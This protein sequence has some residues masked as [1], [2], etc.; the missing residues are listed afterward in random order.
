MK[1]YE[2][3]KLMKTNPSAPTIRDA[4]K[5]LHIDV[6]VFY[7]EFSELIRYYPKEAEH[8]RPINWAKAIRKYPVLSIH[9]DFRLFDCNAWTMLLRFKPD[10]VSFCTDLS[11][12]TKPHWASLI[13]AQP[14]LLKD[15]RVRAAAIANGIDVTSIEL[16]EAPF[17]P[18][19]TSRHWTTLGITPGA[20][21]VILVKP[22]RTIIK[23]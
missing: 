21:T 13:A 22:R 9:C 1:L 18:V 3:A 12:I 20:P 23:E 2:F 16:P 11:I 5:Q 10:H 15:E 6:R 7:R 17:I 19:D 14:I 4:L 8:C